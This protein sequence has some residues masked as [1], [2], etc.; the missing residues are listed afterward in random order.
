[1]TASRQGRRRQR[2][3]RAGVVGLLAVP[4][5]VGVPSPAVAADPPP[6]GLSSDRAAASCWEIKQNVPS[7]TDGIYWLVTPRLQAPERFYCDM[8][9]DGGGW[10]LVGRGREGWKQAYA[11]LG[12]T[13]QVRD[14]VTGTAA[15]GARQLSSRTIDGLLDGGRVDAL[16]GGIRLRRATN[17]T[18][19]AWQEARFTM[20]GR[21]RWVWTFPAEHRVN[22]WNFLGTASGTGGQTNF[23]GTGTGLARVDTRFTAAQGWTSG[24]AYGSSITGTNSSTTYLWSNTNGLGSARPFTQ[25]FLRP[26]LRLANLTFPA[27]PDAGTPAQV[28]PRVHESAALPTAWGV[29]GLANGI[30][31]ELNTEV[32]A[33]TQVGSR[34][35]VG[36]NF[37]Y[38]Q[39]DSAG[40]GRVE[41]RFLAA[42]DVNTRE[43]VSSF[44][45]QLN[46]QVKAL[47][48]LPNGKLVVGGDFSTV[49]GAPIPALV[50][51][52]PATGATDTSWD[53]QVENR[54]TGG[55]PSV[56]G[57]SVQGSWLYLAGNF[58]HVAGGTTTNAAYLRSGGRLAVSN[59]TPDGSWNPNFN[60]TSVGV[61][62]SP[63]GDRVYYAGYFTLANGAT[64][65][66]AAAIRTSAGAP[67]EP[68]TFQGSS[69]ANAN[70]QFTVTEAGDRFYVGG[71][72]HSFFGY[73]RTTFQRTSGNITKAGGDFQASVASQ[74]VVYGGCH[75]NDWN[76]SNAFTWSGVG[77]AWTQ[78]DK[79]GHVGAWTAATGA[80]IPDF[81]PNIKGRV[82]YGPW[83][84]FVDSTDRLWI[85]GDFA[86]AATAS[87]A[88]QWVGGFTQHQVRDG[89]APTRPSNL[90]GTALAGGLTRLSWSGSTDNR[91]P[92]QYEVFRGDRVIGVT[93]G[94]SLDVPSPTEPTRYAVRAVDGA[95]NRSASTPVLTLQASQPRVDLI[96]ERSS[97][98]YRYSAD[99]VPAQWRD[100]G[101]DDSSWA[102]GNAILGFG[103]GAVATD[104]SVGVPTPRP[105]SAHF[106][107]T[108]QVTNPSQLS[109][110]RITVVAD[111]G[112]VVYV[113]GVEVGRVN[114]PT[115][116]IT[117]GS[118]A[119]A[120]PSTATAL[121]N[122]A[123]FTVPAGV[124]VA[125]SNTVSA[126]VH[127]NYRSSPDASFDLGFSAATG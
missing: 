100:V 25:V 64:A 20:A 19:T 116:T 84:V 48:A 45:P 68:W 42:F 73:D 9:T 98:R 127:L 119:T 110:R 126:E 124:L 46:N 39:R 81:E 1:M 57:L 79:I 103:S 21:D 121:A 52:D 75:C 82:G 32:S 59:G 63:N 102:Q 106:R 80:V 71:S 86:I 83:A 92:V 13:A 31:G 27:V 97:W 70:F 17:A 29:T 38:V 111:D 8:T 88:A 7:A 78:A 69:S 122:R 12:T 35:Y 23:F 96:A 36:G 53:A 56:R 37:Q 60:G 108:I 72:E 61:D 125:G 85:G 123:V 118:Y 18:G 65:N 74:G 114:M 44:R 16:P 62:A 76:Y 30:D 90:A 2:L 93:S 113:N 101:F 5:L 91:G 28:L 6:N 50:A 22:T 34:V 66:K 14:V 15:F 51:L 58:T 4:F 104:I 120:A 94:L 87:G 24:W 115:G 49:N 47:A 77:T 89:V 33:F 55:V 95:G 99:T 54:L 67:V 10:V 107:R 11:G 109:D 3:L 105:L 117:Q 41:Q 112:V 43:W 40:T 26:Q